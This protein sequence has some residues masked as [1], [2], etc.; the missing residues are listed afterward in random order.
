MK[1]L[2]TLSVITIALF[3]AGCATWDGL[4]KDSSSAYNSTK[5]TIHEATE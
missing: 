4:K 1:K 2:L 3:S 5:E